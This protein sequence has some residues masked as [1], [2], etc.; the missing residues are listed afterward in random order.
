[1]ERG[2]ALEVRVSEIEGLALSGAGMGLAE[3]L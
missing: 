3:G 1:L 2:K